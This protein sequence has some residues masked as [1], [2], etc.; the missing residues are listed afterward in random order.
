MVAANMMCTGIFSLF[1]A[2]YG[3]GADNCVNAEFVGPDGEFFS[4]NDRAAPNLFSYRD[5]ER[6]LPGICTS[7]SLKLHPV[8]RDEEGLL[9]P[10]SELKLALAFAHTLSQRRIGTAL[11]VLGGEYVSVFMSPNN[12]LAFEVRTVISEKLGIQY[13]VLVIGDQHTLQAV[14]SLG[15]TV[16]DNKLFRLLMLAFPK[17][18]DS[19]WTDILAGISGDRPPYEWLGKAEMRPLLEA[20]L[21]PAADVIAGAVD[22]DLREFFTRLYERPEMTDLVWLTMFRILSSRMGRDRHVLAVILYVP[23][24]DLNLI[25]E[26]HAGLKETTA[27]HGIRGEYGFITPLDEGKRAVFEFDCYFDHT[28]EEERARAKRAFAEL[29][30]VIGE[31]SRRVPAVRWFQHTPYQ[32]FCRSE[33]LL[34]T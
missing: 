26:I 25:E 15:V 18:V 32:G 8:F 20:A 22:E 34:Y 17:L 12:K 7:V 6:G 29:A 13:L 24:H 3:I 11:G 30:A 14:R 31:F 1:S 16:I 23:L 33:H 28:S 21:A 5:E 2:A 27:A 10:F 9:V 19:A 4:L